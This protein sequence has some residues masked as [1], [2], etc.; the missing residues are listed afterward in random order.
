MFSLYATYPLLFASCNGAVRSL[1][2][3]AFG[4][5]DSHQSPSLSSQI[6][7]PFISSHLHHTF[8]FSRLLHFPPLLSS[9]LS[10]YWLVTPSV[11]SLLQ[12]KKCSQ[13]T[14]GPRRPIRRTLSRATTT[15]PRN[16]RW[17][18]C[19]AIPRR[20]LAAYKSLLPLAQGSG[21]L[22]ASL[23]DLTARRPSPAR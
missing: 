16:R 13:P 2:Q 22:S 20:S 12:K 15:S 11:Y 1:C 14:D 7:H 19:M 18:W 10:S 9:L 8:V 21:R 17:G 3:L 6:P 5:L 4:L 23:V